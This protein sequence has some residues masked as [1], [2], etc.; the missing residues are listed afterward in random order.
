MKLEFYK[1]G[2]GALIEALDA[3][4]CPDVGEKVNIRKLNY[5]IVSR[6]W[7]IDTDYLREH[8]VSFRVCLNCEATDNSL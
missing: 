8:P 7:A 2:S 5:L 1:S 6:S 4:S 3:E